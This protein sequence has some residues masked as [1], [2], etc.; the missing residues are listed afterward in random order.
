MSDTPNPK[1]NR[2][3]LAFAVAVWVIVRCIVGLQAVNRGE[4]IRNP[5]SWWL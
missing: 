1:S 4:A 3:R 2:T 5:E